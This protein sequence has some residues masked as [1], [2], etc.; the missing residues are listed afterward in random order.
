MEKERVVVYIPARSGSKRIINK[1]KKLL[2]GKP[3]ILH[4]IEVLN[5]LNWIEQICVSTDDPEIKSLVESSGAIA[6]DLRAK[7]LSDD[8]CTFKNLLEKDISRFEKHLKLN[9]N[10]SILMV[11]PT[12][13]LIDAELLSNAKNKF[14]ESKT[15]FLFAAKEY[16]ISAFWAF[17]ETPDNFKPLFPDKLNE[18]SQDLPKTFSDA[19]LFYF[20]KSNLIRSSFKTWFHAINKTFFIVNKEIAIDVDTPDDW[21]LLEHYFLN[22]KI[23]A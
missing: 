12:A 11:L 16:E 18:R 8:Y 20:L 10:Y 23:K 22:R 15:D 4:V 19:G 13:A 21:K 3:I 6:L 1:N 5:Q 2:D 17:E 9:D 7:E 14:H